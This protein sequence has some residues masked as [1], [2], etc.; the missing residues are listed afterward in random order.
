MPS[1]VEWPISA[2]IL[3]PQW[4][5]FTIVG[6]SFR[7]VGSKSRHDA[8]TWI[9]IPAS[10]A[11]T[12]LKS[13]TCAFSGFII[14]GSHCCRLGATYW[15]LFIAW[16]LCCHSAVWVSTNCYKSLGISRLSSFSPIEVYATLC[17]GCHFAGSNMELVAFS[18]NSYSFPTVLDEGETILI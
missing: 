16:T 6:I 14:F 3:W 5:S 18:C 7:A 12:D 9:V 15:I 1:I 2:R 8:S 4:R 10:L 13:A 17:S 11:L